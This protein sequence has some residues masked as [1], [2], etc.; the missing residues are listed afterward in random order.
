[1][2]AKAGSVSPRVNLG[3]KRNSEVSEAN[4]L[5]LKESDRQASITAKKMKDEPK[6]NFVSVLNENLNQM[7]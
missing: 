4:R 2:P 1:M 5:F 3:D 6:E 7:K